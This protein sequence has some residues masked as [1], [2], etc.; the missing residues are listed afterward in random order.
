MYVKWDLILL[1]QEYSF[2]AG[3]SEILSS[4]YV[5]QYGSSSENW[6]TISLKIQ[7][8]HYWEY[9]QRV[10]DLTFAQLCS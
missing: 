8:Y 9:T 4:Y 2:I 3:G 7:L 10:L 1:E 6:E 5:N